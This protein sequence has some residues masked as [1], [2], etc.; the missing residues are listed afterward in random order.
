MADLLAG[1][2][3]NANDT[4][5][6]VSDRSD[7]AILAFANTSY[8]AGTPAVG[9]A[10]TAPT[11]GRVLVHLSAFLDNSTAGGQSY[12]SFRLGTGSTVGAGT[13]ILAAD[14][15]RSLLV[16]GVDQGRFGI[17]ELVSGLTP[18][19]VYNVQ[20]QHKRITANGDITWRHIIVAPAT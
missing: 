13:Q 1:T 14:D 10:F 19:S 15:S 3:V 4:P 16:T 6:T 9:V 11:T 18:G 8:A 5:P 12:C 7:T 17:T 2:T 20:V